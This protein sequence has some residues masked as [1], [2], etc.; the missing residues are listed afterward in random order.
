MIKGISQPRSHVNHKSTKHV[1]F[2]DSQGPE[3]FSRIVRGSRLQ[4]PSGMVFAE[5][6]K[7]RVLTEI[8]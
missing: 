8:I 5:R 1:P 7:Y 6:E 2:Q 3:L 4:V